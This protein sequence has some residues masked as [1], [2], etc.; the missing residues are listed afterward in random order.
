MPC[1]RL[2][3]GRKQT[4]RL[5]FPAF[6]TWRWMKFV[7]VSMSEERG[8]CSF[9]LWGTANAADTLLTAC[10]VAAG[11]SSISSLSKLCQA[12]F[13]VVLIQCSGKK[14]AVLSLGSVCQLLSHLLQSSRKT[15]NSTWAVTTDGFKIS[16]MLLYFPALRTARYKL[17]LWASLNIFASREQCKREWQVSWFWLG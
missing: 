1:L 8:C 5:V 2:A 10:S 17:L 13:S 15:G 9:S 3:R 16:K 6:C 11:L 14:Q 4:Q 7:C 12:C